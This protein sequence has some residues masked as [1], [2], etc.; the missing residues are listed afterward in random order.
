MIKS[1]RYDRIGARFY[2]LGMYL[3]NFVHKVNRQSYL[4][5]NEHVLAITSDNDEKMADLLQGS[6]YR[7]AFRSF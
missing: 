1:D 2:S 3:S 4:F 6:V 5:G 7:D